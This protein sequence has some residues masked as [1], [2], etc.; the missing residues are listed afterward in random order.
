VEVWT[1]QCV[2]A[3]DEI[4]S[5]DRRSTGNTAF[6]SK[7]VHKDKFRNIKREEKKREQIKRKKR[8]EEAKKR[9]SE[10]EKKRRREEEKKRRRE[11]EKRRREEEK[12]T[13]Q[14]HLA[15]VLCV[16]SPGY[17][18]SD[19]RTDLEFP[20]IRNWQV[21]YGAQSFRSTRRRVEIRQA[22]PP[23]A[24]Q[25]LSKSVCRTPLD[26]HVSPRTRGTET[27]EELR[28]RCNVNATRFP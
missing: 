24:D 23:N 2:R 3:N 28:A 19:L 14:F 15:R 25:E 4:N 21:S 20:F 11:E 22:L 16:H 17:R 8:S 27:N 5:T 10:E 7:E 9:R 26:V 13:F 1:L 6:S 18:K 12:P